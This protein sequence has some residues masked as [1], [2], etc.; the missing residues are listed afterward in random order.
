MK[1]DLS[2]TRNYLVSAVKESEDKIH[3]LSAQVIT[4]SNNSSLSGIAF[5]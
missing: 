2:E 4:H 3:Y 1:L 5:V